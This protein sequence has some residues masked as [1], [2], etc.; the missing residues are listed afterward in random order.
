MADSIIIIGKSKVGQSL[1]KAIRASGRYKLS[2]IV[3]ARSERFPEFES[4]VLIV[5][6]KDEKISDVARKALKQF[7]KKPRFIVHLAGSLESTVLPFASGVA[8]LTLHP[9]QT[10]PKPDAGLVKGIYWMASSDDPAAIRWARQFVA[11]LGSRGIISLPKEA[12]PL[13]HTMTVFGA[14]FTVLLL[15]AIEQM[16]EKLGEDPK[17][18]KSALRPLIEQALTNGLSKPAKNVIT[19]PIA[20]QDYTTISKHQRALKALNPQIRAIYDAFLHYAEGSVI[21][22]EPRNVK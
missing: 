17:R 6:A 4:D 10:F 15:A 8:R 11:S 18:M 2:S 1:A 12:L 5:A 16:S 19:G 7:K 3:S 9:I 21:A 22:R 14:N 20:R 13:Y